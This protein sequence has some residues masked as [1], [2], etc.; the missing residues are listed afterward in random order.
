[1]GV[2]DLIKGKALIRL[3]HLEELERELETMQ[4]PQGFRIIGKAIGKSIKLTVTQEGS[5]IAALLIGH[6]L[7]AQFGGKPF[8][9]VRKESLEDVTEKGW[10]LSDSCVEEWLPEE[11]GEAIRAALAKRGIGYNDLTPREWEEI[12]EKYDLLRKG[13]EFSSK[14]GLSISSFY[15]EKAHA[16]EEKWRRVKS[17]VRKLSR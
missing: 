8:S 15:G 4:F 6:T 11:G 7:I 10:Q 1:M 9:N 13:Y 16:K 17:K 2:A 5:R 3:F 12:F 14:R